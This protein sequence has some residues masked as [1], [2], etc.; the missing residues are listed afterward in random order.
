MVINHIHVEVPPCCQSGQT[1]SLCEGEQSPKSPG[2]GPSSVV[3]GGAGEGGRRG[4]MER[5]EGDAA[6]FIPQDQEGSAPVT[7]KPIH[8]EGTE[9]AFPSFLSPSW[10]CF[11]GSGRHCLAGPAMGCCVMY[12]SDGRLPWEQRERRERDARC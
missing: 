1:A 11:L 7:P 12:P 6:Q 5:V 4:R 3:P 9:I 10:S 8:D 2:V